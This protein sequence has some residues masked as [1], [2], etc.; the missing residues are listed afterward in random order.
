MPR[1]L[2]NIEYATF[3]TE[4][5]VQSL[6]FPPWGGIVQWGSQDVLVFLG[7]KQWNDV[8]QDY[9]QQIFLSDVTDMSGAWKAQ[10]QQQY[11]D[12]SHVY[13]WTLGESLLNGIL[14]EAQRLGAVVNTAIDS[15]G[16]IVEGVGTLGANLSS[17]L[18]IGSAVLIVYMLTYGKKA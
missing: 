6:G 15:T 11:S 13:W 7:T 8:V 2:S 12:A 17:V 16:K 9:A 3:L 10:A 18:L 14:D 4:I 1:R 5:D